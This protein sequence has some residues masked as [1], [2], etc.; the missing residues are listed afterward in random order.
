MRFQNPDA[1][2]LRVFINQIRRKIEEDPTQP[3]YIVTEPDVGYRFRVDD[4]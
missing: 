3:R 2:K 4:E 1:A